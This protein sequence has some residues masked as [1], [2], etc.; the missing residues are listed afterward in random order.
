MKVK[1]WKEKVLIPTYQVG[2]PE[3]MPV[4]LEQRVYQGSSGEVYPNPVIEKVFDEKMEMEWIGLFIENRYLKIMILPELGGRVQMAF[5]KIKQK[6]FIYYNEVIKPALVGLTGPWISGGIEFNWPQHH[7]PSTYEPVDYN[8][9]ENPDGSKTVWVSEVERM[10]RTKGMAGFTLYEGKAYLEVRVKLFNRTSHPQTFLWWANPAVSVNESYQSVFPPDVNA[11]FDHGKRDVSEFPVARGTYYKVDYSEGVD[12]SYYGNIPV[13]TSYMAINSKYDFL[14][15][16]AHDTG[17]GILHVANHHIAPGKKQW[18]WGNGDFGKAW[19]RNLTDKNGPYIELMC[20]AYTD[21]Q[22]DFSWLQPFEEKAFSQFFMPYHDI[23]IVKDATR[24][25]MVSLDFNSGNLTVKVYVTGLFPDCRILLEHGDETLLE[26][27]VSLSPESV[28]SKT[29]CNEGKSGQAEYNLRVTDCQGYLLVGYTSEPV[30]EKPTPDPATPAPEPRD[31]ESLEQLFLHGQH[32]EQYRHATFDP[33]DYY[34]EALRREPSDIRSNN[35]MGLWLLRRGLYDEAEPYFRTAVRSLTRRNPNPYEGEPLFNLGLSLF[36]QGRE[37]EAYS[38]FYKSVWNAAWQDAGFLFLARLECRKGKFREALDNV[39][40]SLSRNSNNHSSR[41]LKT[42]LLRKTGQQAAAGKWIDASLATD[43]F[44]FGIRYERYLIS[45]NNEDLDKMVDMMRDYVHNYIEYSLDYALAGFHQEAVSM[46]DLYADN[47]NQVYPMVYYLRGWYHSLTRDR[48][49]AGVDYLKASGLKPDYC[50]P[51]RIEESIALKEALELNPDDGKGWYYLGNFWYANKQYSKAAECWEKSIHAD[52]SFS[53]PYRNLSLF[54]YNKS[55]NRD[56]ALNLLKTACELDPSPR[57][58][59]EL[60]QL[61]KKLGISLQKRLNFIEKNF[62]QV[63]FRDDLY[64]ERITLYNL[65]RREDEAL[66]LILNR[67]FHP[68]EGGEG[69]VSA[70]YI[71]SHMELAKKAVVTGNLDIAAKHLEEARSFPENLGEGKLHG[72]M[73]N[74]LLFWIGVVLKEMEKLREASECWEEATNGTIE[75]QDVRYYNDQPPDRILYQGLSLRKLGRQNEANDRFS[76]LVSYGEE[77]MDRSVQKDYFAVSLPD[78][79]IFE[80]DP[81]L[82]NLQHCRYLQGLGWLGFGK[83]GD[84]MKW[85]QAI[86]KE[87]PCHVGAHVHV[88]LIQKYL[89]YL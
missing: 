29:L 67:N 3:I 45:R 40:R 75:P 81:Q 80:Q 10:S 86:L 21:N 68:W 64:L 44:N 78:L 4:F 9:E 33:R 66:D 46:L 22:P 49:Q 28:Y 39:E 79:L 70:Q 83:T 13:P 53:I 74:D 88:N 63:D 11:V 76:R 32:L 71:L 31:V 47:A 50:F 82:I 60:D 59:M 6:H 56:R 65:S 35:A 8:I 42:V 54:C 84:A 14:G 2:I 12:I 30:L 36:Y 25:A 77:N 61:H 52:A 41:H 15:G 19:E 85:F 57:M 62:E 27:T 20:G 23:G 24:D 38:A 26:E 48:E 58:V 18:T 87:D 55:G 89:M 51:N 7:R 37:E 43:L 72:A 1:A 17:C 16:Y 5:D 73:E 34:G 69:K